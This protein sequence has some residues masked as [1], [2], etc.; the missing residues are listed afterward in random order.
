MVIPLSAK[1]RMLD[2]FE[3]FQVSLI[4]PLRLDLAG[5]KRGRTPGESLW[6]KR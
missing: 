4:L 1:W 5:L 6:R 2:Y 3:L